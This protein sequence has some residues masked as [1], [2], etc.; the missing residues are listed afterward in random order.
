MGRPPAEVVIRNR[1]YDADGRRWRPVAGTETEELLTTKVVEASRPIVRRE[2]LEVLTNCAPPIEADQGRTGLVFGYVQSGKTLSFTAVAALALDNGYPLVIVIAG[3]STLLSKQSQDRLIDDLRLESRDDR[4]WVNI[5]NPRT[6]AEG[7]Q[8]QMAL[9]DWRDDGIPLDQKRTA[10]VTVMKEWRHLDHL[11]TLVRDLN[12]YGRTALIVDDEADQAGL[13]NLIS[14]GDESTIYR[15]LTELKATVPRHTFLQYT[16]TPQG[17]L[18]INIIDVLSPTFAITLTPGG[19]YTGGN[20]FFVEH[21]ELVRDIPDHEIPSRTHQLADVPP[22]LL[23]ALRIFYLGVA[24]GFLRG[25]R[26]NRSMM[27]HPSQTTLP[28]ADYERWVSAASRMW[29]SVVDGGAS[30]ERDEVIGLFRET[31]AD[32]ART[33]PNLE[34]FDALVARLPYAIANT[35]IQEINAVRG[36]TPRVNWR[37]T[38]SHILVGGQALDR[39]FTVEGLTVTYMPRGPGVGNADT[40]Q[41]RARF[42]GYKRPYLGFCRVYLEQR[43]REAFERYVEHEGDV[44]TA[45]QAHLNAGRPLS[46]LKRVFLLD[47]RLRPTRDAIIDI[48]YLRQAIGSGWHRI[49]RPMASTATLDNNRR[50]VQTFV[51]EHQWHEWPGH[52]RRTAMQK[53]EFVRIGL[54]Q[55]LESFLTGLQFAD[56]DDAQSYLATLYVLTRHAERAPDAL[57]T[58]VRMSP[59]AARERGVAADGAVLQLFQGEYPVARENRGEIYGGDKSIHEADCVCVQIHN[60]QLTRDGSVV[61]TNVPTIAIHVPDSIPHDVIIQNQP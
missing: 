42:F 34:P 31:H 61:A 37:N 38:Y 47:Q 39:G 6:H 54:A 58:I 56:L 11:L 27:V 10:L 30:S 52:L 32:L 20:A 29:R 4:R 55:A 25:G 21:S 50:T 1:P 44:M 13:N 9:D 12:L 5:H 14:Q 60:L 48:A 40:I 2:A 43:V 36:H 24:S 8:I 53:H 7:R 33:V 17:P 59:G 28:H 3:T 26:G 51:E 57:C 18:L 22:S 35:N 49:N 16:A 19:D 45:L 23:D 41:Q 15:K 46:E